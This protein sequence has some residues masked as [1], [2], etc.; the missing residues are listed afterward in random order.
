[1]RNPY[2]KNHLAESQLFRNRVYVT[3]VV[4]IAFLILLAV[5]LYYLQ[6]EQFTTYT[7]LAE[8]NRVTLLPIAPNRG[9]IYDRNGVLLV[10]NIPAYS[11]HIIPEKVDKIADTINELNR[12][13]PID[14]DEQK[15]FYQQL[16]YRRKFEGVPLIVNLDENT[17]A[18]FSVNSYKFPGVKIVAELMRYYPYQDVFSHSIGYVGRI[19]EQEMAQIDQTIYSASHYI[20]KTGIEQFYEAELRGLPGYQHAET[21]VRGRIVRILKSEA[22]THGNDIYLTIDQQLQMDVFSCN[23]RKRGT[24]GRP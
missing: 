18:K 12:L 7:T 24:H 17:A 15:N 6:V 22:P 10:E 13:I 1:M 23:G 21:N 8:Q 11:L 4:I 2:L 9:L 5:R 16:K 3:G 14:V 19:N 20:G